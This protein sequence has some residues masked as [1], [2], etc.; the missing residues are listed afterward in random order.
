[1]IYPLNDSHFDRS[2]VTSLRQSA[3]GV[4]C[5][6]CI[7]FL[8]FLKKVMFTGTKIEI[9]GEGL[10]GIRSRLLIIMLRLQLLPPVGCHTVG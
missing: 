2:S 8:L 3:F 6:P 4:V 5:R 7:S 1:M 10:D 9:Q